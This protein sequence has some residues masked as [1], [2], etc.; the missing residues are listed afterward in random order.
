MAQ[1]YQACFDVQTRCCV[2]PIGDRAAAVRAAAPEMEELLRVLLDPE[3][4]PTRCFRTDCSCEIH[5]GRALLDR[6]DK[7][8]KEPVE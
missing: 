2:C 7:V 6:L 4:P 8:G 1:H 3:R 5:R